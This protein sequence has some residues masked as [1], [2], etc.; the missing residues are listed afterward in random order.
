VM[1]LDFVA[2][3]DEDYDF[4]IKEELYDN[5]LIQEFIE[6]IKSKEFQRR[7]NEL[8]GYGF[9]RTGEIIIIGE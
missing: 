8:G 7:V 9:Q 5:K 6:L 2:L 3:A 4:L 1:D